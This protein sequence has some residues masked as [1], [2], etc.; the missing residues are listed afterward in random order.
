M[1]Y[2]KEAF[3]TN[4]VASLGANVDDFEKKIAA[5]VGVTHAAALVFGTS[6]LHFTLELTE[7]KPGDIVFCSDLT[8][9][10]K[11]NPVSNGH[12]TQVFIDSERET[13]NMDPEAL[14]KASKNILLVNRHHRQ[15]LR[16]AR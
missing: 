6:A 10:A 14:E 12:A 16:H 5:N 7:I 3:D 8:I 15:S 9:S 1:Q 11:V 4:W 13:W 2:I